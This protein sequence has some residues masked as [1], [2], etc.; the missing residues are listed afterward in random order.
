MGRLL[1]LPFFMTLSFCFL[2]PL[3]TMGQQIADPE[4][5]YSRIR[6]VALSGHYQ[7]AALAARQLLKEYPG[8]GDARVLLGRVLAWDGQYQ[9]AAAVID[10]LLVTDPDNADAQSARLD[11]AFW[12]GDN[13]L[14]EKMAAAL[15]AENPTDTTVREKLIKALLAQ[16]KREQALAESDSLLKLSP[17]NTFAASLR[18]PQRDIRRYDNI[19]LTYSFDSHTVPYRRFWQQAAIGGSHRFE[20]GSAGAGVNI[21]HIRTESADIVTATELQFEVEA[22]PVLSSRNYAYINYAFSPGRYYPR[23]RASLEVWEMMP[24]GWAVS[25]GVNY[26]YFDR[27]IFIAGL[28]LEKYL[29]NYWFSGKALFYFKDIGVT[30][31]FYLTARRYFNDTD[32][33]QL[34]LGAGTAPDEPFDIQT[35]LARQSAYSVRLTYFRLLSDSFAIRAH[36]GYS[37]EEY[38]SDG[39]RNRVEG[40]LGLVYLFNKDK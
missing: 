15:L 25:A 18:E 8:Y 6:A 37:A 1:H 16:G 11:I 40:S 2:F 36:A 4:A 22:A 34:V 26:Y 10:S 35:D 19:R 30:T 21:G 32:Y 20:R 3:M 28:S 14:A 7:E 12:S 29:G 17:E 5:E 24:A 9:E 31:S 23:H 27:N 13:A 33:L 39:F 38:S